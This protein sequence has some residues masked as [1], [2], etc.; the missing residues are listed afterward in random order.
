MAQLAFEANQALQRQA[1]DHAD[2]TERLKQEAVL[3]AE[4]MAN[5]MSAKQAAETKEAQVA[6]NTNKCNKGTYAEKER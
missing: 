4:N 3:H 5:Y 1:Q 6:F 2:A